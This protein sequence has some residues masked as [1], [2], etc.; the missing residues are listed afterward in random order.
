MQSSDELSKRAYVPIRD[1]FLANFTNIIASNRVGHAPAAGAGM[2]LD[3]ATV[4]TGAGGNSTTLSAR[5]RQSDSGVAGASDSSDD[6]DSSDSS[7]NSLAGDVG[8]AAGGFGG[9]GR[10]LMQDVITRHELG[11]ADFG[12]RR[13]GQD[14]E[15]DSTASSDDS[16]S[17]ENELEYDL[18]GA[19][20]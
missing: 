10:K 15:T 16:G 1:D 19:S 4:P 18:D 20:R 3:G 6:S 17:A 8:A 14:D 2:A 12:A 7:R 9:G 13:A 5:K 11:L